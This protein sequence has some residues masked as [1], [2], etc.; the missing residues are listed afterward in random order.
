VPLLLVS[1]W[2]ESPTPA[3]FRARVSATAQDGAVVPRLVT[4]DPRQVVDA[5]E[6]WLAGLDLA[7]RDGAETS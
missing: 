2:F 1:V 4:A 6:R 5:V 7:V 3:G